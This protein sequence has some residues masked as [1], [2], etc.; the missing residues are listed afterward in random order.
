MKNRIAQI[1]KS[2]G[3]SQKDLAKRLGIAPPT[4]SQIEHGGNPRIKTLARIAEELN[5]KIAELI[6]E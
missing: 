3:I 5:C 4:L 1:R 2:K 6:N